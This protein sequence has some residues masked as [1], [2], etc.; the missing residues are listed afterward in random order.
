M[1][2]IVPYATSDEQKATSLRISY[3][4]SEMVEAFLAA[5]PKIP[6]FIKAAAPV[7]TKYFGQPLEMVLEVMSYPEEGAEEDLIGWIQSH[8]DVEEGLNKLERF[9]DEW[10]LDHMAEV[11]YRFNFNLETR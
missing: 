7:L 3:R 9:E 5:Y 10:F 6:S 8:D 2:K 1:R 11:D 4:N